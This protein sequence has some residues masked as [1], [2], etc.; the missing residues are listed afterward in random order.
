MTAD[1]NKP[2]RKVK[3]KYPTF[4]ECLRHRLPIKVPTN[5]LAVYKDLVKIAYEE[6]IPWINDDCGLENIRCN[7]LLFGTD[8]VG[9]YSMMAT[10]SEG[11]YQVHNVAEYLPDVDLLTQV[12]TINKP[13]KLVKTDLEPP[14]QKE[15]RP[16]LR[17]LLRSCRNIKIRVTPKASCSQLLEI[18]AEEGL[19]WVSGAELLNT[20]SYKYLFVEYRPSKGTGPGATEGGYSVSGSDYYPTFKSS[21]NL[22]YRTDREPAAIAGR[23]EPVSPSPENAGRTVPVREMTWEE[24][25]KCELPCY[26]WMKKKGKYSLGRLTKYERNHPGGLPFYGLNAYWDSC[27]PVDSAIVIVDPPEPAQPKYRPFETFEEL[28]KAVKEHGDWVDCHCEEGFFR[29]IITF[30]IT[31]GGLKYVNGFNLASDYAEKWTFLDGTPFGVPVD[32]K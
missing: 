16:L 18:M 1:K 27:K 23:E 24:A 19:R 17:K 9:P 22:E 3:Q 11:R 28:M 7:A 30:Q 15:S 6:K 21:K 25:A 4:R 13:A 8:I 12:R 26:L 5:T 20:D 31:A 10:D 29:K 14:E 2:G 32:K